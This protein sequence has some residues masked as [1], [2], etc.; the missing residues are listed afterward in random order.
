MNIEDKYTKL[1]K[2]EF[3]KKKYL[4]NTLLINLYLMI[5][6]QQI[7]VLIGYLIKKCHLELTKMVDIKTE[8]V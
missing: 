3:Q 2:Q 5:I 1:K 8:Y 4:F 6:N 7:I